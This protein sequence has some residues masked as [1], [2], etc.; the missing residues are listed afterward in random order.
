MVARYPAVVRS[1]TYH[2]PG[3]RRDEQIISTPF[4][5]LAQYFLRYTVRIAVGRIKQIDAGFQAEIDLAPRTV[6]IGC[7]YLAEDRAATEG[8]RT[9]TEHR[10]HQAGLSK[11]PI[12]HRSPIHHESIDCE[13]ITG[14]KPKTQV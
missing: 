6:D 2:H 3:L 4:Q 1:R 9:Q 13:Q 7:S 5:G 14:Q 12:F 8:H 11:L 10:N